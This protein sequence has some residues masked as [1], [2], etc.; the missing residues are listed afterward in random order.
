[1]HLHSIA[2]SF[3]LGERQLSLSSNLG[4]GRALQTGLKYALLRNYDIV[5]TLDADGQHRPEDVP[6]LVQALID[7]NADMVIG[8]RFTNNRSY[9]AALSRRLGQIIF[10]K[11]TTLLTNQR[12]FDTSSGFKVMNNKVC[13]A[14]VNATF[15][16]FH[17][18]TIVRLSL[19]GFKIKE[20]PVDILERNTGRSMH[21]FSSVYEYPLR[22]ILLTAA[23]VMDVLIERR[24]R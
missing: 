8:S 19:L 6:V 14:I 13:Q 18:E 4:Y 20:V 22:T 10:S 21:S 5:V 23:A 7:Q 17:I 16:D 9:D 12:I 1:M 11:L 2:W 3:G 15:M 24:T